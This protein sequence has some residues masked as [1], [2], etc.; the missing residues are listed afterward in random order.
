MGEKTSRIRQRLRETGESQARQLELV[1][2]DKGFLIRGTLGK[3]RRVC[4]NPSCH[5]ARGERHEAIYLSASDGGQTRQI[6][7]PVEQQDH[8]AAGVA[9]YRRFRVAKAKLAELAQL[10]LALVDELGRSLL[11]PYP[12]ERPLAAPRRIP[13][14]LKGKGETR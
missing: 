4:G 2:E 7:V 10:Q 12:P 3:R 11:E 9:R 1:L 13:R 8:V 14:R 5:C 6:H